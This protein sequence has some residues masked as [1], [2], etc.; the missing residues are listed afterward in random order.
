MAAA[1]AAEAERLRFDNSNDHPDYKNHPKR[2]K[3]IKAV[4]AN[5]GNSQSVSSNSYSSSLSEL[6]VS[7]SA[8]ASAQSVSE[9]SGS[10]HYNNY[11]VRSSNNSSSLYNQSP[12]TPPT[13]PQQNSGTNS[14]YS[15]MSLNTPH[16]NDTESNNTSSQSASSGIFYRTMSQSE[17]GGFE[18]V[19]TNG[20]QPHQPIEAY[21]DHSL[22]PTPPPGA[23]PQHPS[24]D[25]SYTTAT[26]NSPSAI[27]WPRFVDSRSGYDASVNSGSNMSINKESNATFP[28]FYRTYGATNS[29]CHGRQFPTGA[30]IPATSLVD[31]APDLTSSYCAKA[32]GA[33]TAASSGILSGVEGCTVFGHTDPFTPR[34]S[35]FAAALMDETDWIDL[36]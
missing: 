20:N 18:P 9:I 21:V 6:A 35:S 17:F 25:Y 19:N 34:S 23:T 33:A 28:D 14:R 29:D 5:S 16:S 12:P 36:L 24:P 1:A 7:G 2:R 27:S 8:K 3:V 4:T 15:L 32:L 26:S 31:A 13:T 10:R 30:T 11:H 22:G